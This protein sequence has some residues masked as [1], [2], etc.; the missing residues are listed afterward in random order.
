MV[1]GE[2]AYRGFVNGRNL[3]SLDKLSFWS[4]SWLGDK[5]WRRLCKLELALRNRGLRTKS[6]RS[7]PHKALEVV[8][9]RPL[10]TTG[11]SCSWHSTGQEKK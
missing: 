11:S 3:Q 6:G 4:I 10:P 9:R 5:K 1:G 2:T 7:K 8:R